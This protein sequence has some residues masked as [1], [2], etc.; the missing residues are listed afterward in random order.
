M[1]KKRSFKVVWIVGLAALFLVG[2]VLLLEQ[3]GG[4]EEVYLEHVHGLGYSPDGNRIMI[5]SHHGIA[6]YEQGGWKMKEGDQHDYMGFSIV[7]DGFYS[8]GH[9]EKG[10][11]F[12]N[13]FGLI[14]GSLENDKIEI[15]SLHGEID[16][17]V[18]S[19]SYSTHTV[20]VLNDVPNSMMKEYGI[21]YTQD[22]GASWNKAEMGGLGAEEEILS[23]V[24]HPT[25]DAIVAVGTPTGL[26]LSV[27][28]GKSFDKVIPDVQITAVHFDSQGSLYVGG[29][30]SKPW[31]IEMDV[32]NGSKTEISIPSM[33]KDAVSYVAKNPTADE[34]VITTYKKDVYLSSDKGQTWKKVADMGKTLK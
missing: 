20:Y 16:F 5:P 9:P 33:T 2:A 29:H 10:T 34:L 22:D 7:D 14:K 19:A 11:G 32:D 15:L 26:Y 1:T 25:N 12:K 27:N 17:H 24:V 31:L 4:D 23:L 30:D 3:V 13:P 8:S 28:H 21:Y 18:M 6:V